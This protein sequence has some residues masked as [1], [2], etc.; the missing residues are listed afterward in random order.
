MKEKDYQNIFVAQ[1]LNAS[2]D[3]PAEL[4]ELINPIGK[5][6][7]TKVMSV[8]ADDYKYRMLEAM[9]SNFESIWMVLGD[10]EFKNQIF[11]YITAYPSKNFDLNSY[12]ENLPAFLKKADNREL[13]SEMPFLPDLAQFEIL[14]WSIFHKKNPEIEDVQDFDKNNLLQSRFSFDET[15]AF[16]HL[17]HHVFPLFQF[18]EKTLDDFLINHSP[19]IIMEEA[20]YIL[21]KKYFKVNCQRLT[22]NQYD[23]FQL[24]KGRMTFQ[25]SL[26]NSQATPQ[27]IQELFKFL[28]LNFINRIIL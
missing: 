18:R 20:Y 28:S 11:E 26:D 3:I 22:K 17:G 21:Y 25:E 10:E 14:F 24:L 2:S 16:M 13:I 15:I 19:E 1:T 4:G 12:G 9:K 23:F 7:I 8:Y 5:I 6:D 27:E